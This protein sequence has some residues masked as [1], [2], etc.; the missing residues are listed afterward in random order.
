M[1]NRIFRFSITVVLLFISFTSFV[2]S[3]NVIS[4]PYSRFGLGKLQ[5]SNQA[6]NMSMGGIGYGIRNSSIIN[7]SNPASYNCADTLSFVFETGVYSN[8]SSL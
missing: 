5:N 1:T 8:F 4:S 3:Q 6:F 7:F 2:H